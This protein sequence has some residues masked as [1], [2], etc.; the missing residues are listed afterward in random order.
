MCACTPT[1]SRYGDACARS[2][3]SAAAP[4]ATRE[5]ELGVLLAGAHE[6]V[7]VRF[8]AGRHADQHRRPDR[9]RRPT[10]RADSARRTSP[11]RCVR[12]RSASAVR[13]SSSRL[14]VAVQHQ[15]VGRHARPRERRGT[16]RPS[17]RR[18]SCPR[19]TA[20]RG[21]R[22]A[23]EGLGRVV[24]PW[25]ERGHRLAT[26]RPDVLLVVDE[27]RRTEPIGQVERVATCDRQLA[28]SPTDALSGSSERG[29]TLTS[30]PAPS[31]RTGRARSSRPIS[32]ASTSHSRAWVSSGDTSSP[33]T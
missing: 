32:A 6:L 9:A 5:P 18:G 13:S 14:V 17:T 11:R 30:T 25:T 15:P 10:P 7:R 3:A 23:E 2:T 24:H 28:R 1:R 19:R 4:D 12:R 16:R 27:Q 22:L 8:D 29:R 20:K 26:A 21:H 33:S 31:H